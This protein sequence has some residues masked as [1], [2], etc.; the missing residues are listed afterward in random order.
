MELVFVLFP[1]NPE[2][3]I[4]TEITCIKCI[5]QFD[6]HA[7]FPL[8]SDVMNSPI[9]QPIITV[10]IAKAILVIVPTA[11]KVHIEVFPILENL[12]KGKYE[13]YV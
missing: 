8:V 4:K 13:K 3:F 12:S 7:G 11:A 9:T 6:S 5:C 1:R 2:N 10:G